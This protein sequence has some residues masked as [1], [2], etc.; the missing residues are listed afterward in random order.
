MQTADFFRDIGEEEYQQW[1]FQHDEAKASLVSRAAKV[2]AVGELIEK[3]L[4]LLGAT[5]IED[6]LQ[7][8]CH[9]FSHCVRM[10]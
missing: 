5:A 1:A 8:V 3:N 9:Q 4:I 2:A 10:P 6:K 7:E